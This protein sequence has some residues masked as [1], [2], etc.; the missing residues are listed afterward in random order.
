MEDLNRRMAQ[1]A[2]AKAHYEKLKRQAARLESEQQ[3]AAARARQLKDELAKEERDVERLEGTSL[4]GLLS[5]LFGNKEEKLY[6]EREEAAAALIRFEEAKHQADQLAAELQ[7]L[8]SQAAQ[9]AG[10]EATYQSL[11]SEKERLLRSERGAAADELLRFEQEEARLQAQVREVEEARRAGQSAEAGL[12]RVRSALNSAEG[13]GTWDMLGGGWI[14]TMAKHSSIDEAQR[15]LHMAQSA[16]AGFRRELADVAGNLELPSVELDGFTRFADYFFDNFF[17]DWMVQSRINEAQASVE[18]A[19]SQVFQLNHWLADQSQVL[20]QQ[21]E[22]TRLNRQ[23]FIS[24][25]R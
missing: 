10:A 9:L 4:S 16:L 13:W 23:Q 22:Q 5:S 12:D 11:L 2:E 1:A 17:V 6:Q 25:F 18:E 15:E 19:R 14:S 20:Q 8:Q 21:L 24:D 7:A 3:Q